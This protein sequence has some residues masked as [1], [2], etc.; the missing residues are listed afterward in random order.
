M[1]L[2]FV[3][4]SLLVVETLLVGFQLT[5]LPKALIVLATVIVAIMAVA[6][7]VAKHTKN[8]YA[9]KFAKEQTH[10]PPR[11]FHQKH[12]VNCIECNKNDKG[13]FI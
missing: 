3:E 8:T 7:L 10:E 11:S 13:R 1:R 9:L 4:R 5:E 12:P 6:T 2:P